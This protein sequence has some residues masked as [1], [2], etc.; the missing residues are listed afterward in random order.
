M[1]NRKPEHRRRMKDKRAHAQIRCVAMQI[2]SRS[3]LERL[4]RGMSPI[5][6]GETLRLMRPHLPA[7]LQDYGL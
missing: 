5:V 2:G 4:L 1:R 3:Q 6:E 7:D